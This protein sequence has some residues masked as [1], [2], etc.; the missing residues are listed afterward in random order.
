M[1]TV[2]VISI[3]VILIV[4]ALIGPNHRKRLQLQ[5]YSRSGQTFARG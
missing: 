5:A 1:I 4:L 3:I 2:L